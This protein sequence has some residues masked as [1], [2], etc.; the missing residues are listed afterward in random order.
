MRHAPAADHLDLWRGIDDAV[1]R[2]AL[3][4]APPPRPRFAP[5]RVAGR[6]VEERT[7]APAATKVP[8]P[9]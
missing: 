1:W 8:E 4:L 9:V 5:P 3:R 2:E 6:P 7:T